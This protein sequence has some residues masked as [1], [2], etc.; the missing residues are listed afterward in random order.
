VWHHKKGKEGEVLRRSFDIFVLFMVAVIL[1]MVVL[2]LSEGG[3][4]HDK[5]T[6]E[7]EIVVIPQKN[8]IELDKVWE[9]ETD[10]EI[11]RKA[12][13]GDTLYAIDDKQVI[14]IIDINTGKLIKSFKAKIDEEFSCYGISAYED[15][16]AIYFSDKIYVLD[17]ESEKVLFNKKVGKN[18]GVTIGYDIYLYKN[19]VL[20]PDISDDM[21]YAINYKTGNIVW[22]FGKELGDKRGHYRLYKYKDRYFFD[23]PVADLYYEFD[24]LTGE[25]LN[26]YEFKLGEEIAN[27][28]Q[29]FY[30]PIF[31]NI[32]DKEFEHWL[33]NNT[34]DVFTLTEKGYMYTKYRNKF[35]FHGIDSDLDWMIKLPK[36]MYLTYDYGRYTFLGQTN[37]ISLLDLEQKEIIWNEDFD[38][39]DNISAFI[40]ESKLYISTSEK[41]IVYDL[42]KLEQYQYRGQGDR[43]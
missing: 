39:N 41:Y 42:S 28:D 6:N 13:Q 31:E 29:D 19:L 24:P 27:K 23:N 9:L 8:K 1:L 40:Y 18:G 7:N 38:I 20:Y 25:I 36:E 10:G 34:F 3:Y 43:Y 21:I 22:E 11:Y 26:S 32:E 2:A 17:I 33:I 30:I 35:Y 5:D 4:F 16:I 37:S 15:T 12:M 14:Y